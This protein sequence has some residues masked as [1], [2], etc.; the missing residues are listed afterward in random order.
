MDPWKVAPPR[1]NLAGLIKSAAD[2]WKT[3]RLPAFGEHFSQSPANGS[4]QPSSRLPLRA[5][6]RFEVWAGAGTL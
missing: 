5:D 1:Q 4:G 6:R 2:W 3:L